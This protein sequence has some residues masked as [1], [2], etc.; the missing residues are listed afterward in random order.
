MQK[1]DMATVASGSYNILF[2]TLLLILNFLG[3]LSSEVI[4]VKDNLFTTEEIRDM[5]TLLSHEETFWVFKPISQLKESSN[6]IPNDIQGSLSR[7]R[8]ANTCFSWTTNLPLDSFK[9]SSPWRKLTETLSSN[10]EAN[11][12]YKIL[13]FEGKINVRGTHLC[14]EKWIVNEQDFASFVAIIFL[15][16]W[17]RNSYGELVIYNNKGEI[18]KAVYPKEGRLVV[19]PS[20]L[21]H[22][23]KPLANDLSAGRLYV[24]KFHISVSGKTQKIGTTAGEKAVGFSQY[25]PSFK[26]L[27]KADAFSVEK[28]DVKQFVTRN[29]TTS[30]G[31]HI[32]V[33]D[34]IIPAKEL[35]AL[36]Y[37]IINGG[38]NDNAAGVD[39]TDNVQW[40]M[41]FE[42]EEFVQTSLWQ[43]ASQII[44]AVS[45]KEGY[46]PY[47]IGCNNIQN[48]DTTTIHTDCAS[49]ENEF[50]LL[51]YLNQ[52]WT[53]NHH[54][55]TVFFNDEESEVIFAV[56]PK[57]GRVAVFH[58]TIPHS[59]RPPPVTFAGARLSFAVKLSPSKEIAERKSLSVETDTF[60]EAL[61][62][63][64]GTEVER[65]RNIL[66]D[67][68]EGKLDAEAL[69]RLVQEYEEKLHIV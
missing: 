49:H 1:L 10:F 3:S 52:N 66:K 51:I 63:L 65:V 17:K 11:G 39:S 67:L 57:Y 68:N 29:F 23:L 13:G 46:Y 56:R 12:D 43:L 55:E 38:Y 33:L 8:Q 4:L 28:E 6:D 44:R 18:L 54:G 25:I 34:D 53:E 30:D 21:E 50:T 19:F 5:K 9:N 2:F 58:G 60:Y 35:D 36:R 22:V 41:A 69:E 42:V 45:G 64:Q 31:R 40:I 37:T 14:G 32:V 48:M 20:A 27:T 61:E 7:A 15:V 59:A 47:D 26:H 24:M 16:D 62:T